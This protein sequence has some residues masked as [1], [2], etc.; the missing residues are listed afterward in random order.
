MPRR[1]DSAEVKDGVRLP[2]PQQMSGFRVIE[3]LRSCPPAAVRVPCCATR[4]YSGSV[5]S[6][7]RAGL[8][9]AASF[10]LCGI[11]AGAAGADVS[12]PPP[13]AYQQLRYDESYL[14]L[15][16]PAARSDYLDVIKFIPMT[17]N[18]ASYLTL[19]GEIRERYEYYH[20]GLWGNG[21]PDDN[22]YLLQRY[23]AHADAHF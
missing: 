19:G 7:R 2:E 15:R 23:M 14:Y 22:G 3:R 17:T 8:V 5:G 12:A 10:I 20:N 21:V 1:G 16:D 4:M 11:L 18:G 13:P 6:I 9:A